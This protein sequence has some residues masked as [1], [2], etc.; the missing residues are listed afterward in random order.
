[1][2]KHI[3]LPRAL[4]LPEGKLDNM[5]AKQVLYDEE[6]L[7]RIQLGID[8]VA[9]TVKITLGPL[10]RNVI[11][12]A[13]PQYEDPTIINDGVRIARQIFPEGKF[14]QTGAKLIKKV[15][16]K[17]N[18]VA[19]DGTTTA[20]ILMQAICKSALQ[21][22]GN[23]TNPVILRRGIEEA[24]AIILADLSQQAVPTDDL[25][26]LISVATISCGDPKLG[27]IVAEVVHK[28]GVD[29]VIA[30]EDSEGEETI[31]ELSE[32][33]E[34]RGG[35]Q[36]PIFITHPAR[37]LAQL[38]GV[39][40]FVTDHDLTNGLE[41]MKIMEIASKHGHKAAVVIANSISGEAM[42]TAVV[43]RAQGKFNLLP[44]RVQAWGE[45]GQDLLRDV[46]AVTG[47]KFFAKEE[48]F[49][50]PT[51]TNENYNFDHFGFADRVIAS[52]ERTTIVGGGGDREARIEEVEAQIP[53]IKVAFKKEQVKERVAR[54]KSGVGT[55][56]VGAVGDTEREERRLRVEDAINATKA[57]LAAG[58]VSGG[59]SALYR[60]ACHIKKQRKGSYIDAGWAAVV[61]ACEAPIRQMA[62]NS[63]LELSRSDLDVI[64]ESDKTTFDFNTGEVVDGIEKGIIDPV[65]VVMTALKSASSEVAL[66][67]TSGAAVVTLEDKA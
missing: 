58:I 18:D 48:G 9:N 17:T 4:R 34:L 49:R 42:A 63:G 22:L 11:L 54:L 28:L 37:Q 24:T 61:N 64:V 13:N 14:E 7:K 39:P 65:K 15:A 26:S 16:E 5:E 33:L 43:N 40:I 53:N 8:M 50:L 35:W 57:A 1:M 19:G 20:T 32:G 2:A 12:D 6:A 44:I 21:Q 3:C 56:S 55:I 36:L 27:K 10:G 23:G 66:F 62:I 46:A 25:K 47:A 52:K 30:L 59:G 41:A 31:S 38:D 29:G 45:T 51:N 60:A 67:I